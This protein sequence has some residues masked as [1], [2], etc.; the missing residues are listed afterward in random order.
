MGGIGLTLAFNWQT[1]QI[2]H[3]LLRN[4]NKT[5]FID[6]QFY[7]HILSIAPQSSIRESMVAVPYLHACSLVP[8]RP[9]S[10]HDLEKQESHGN[11]KQSIK[12]EEH[13]FKT[14]LDISGTL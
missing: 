2:K 5:D 14:Q 8:Y 10:I 12:S 6:I 3:S 9:L 7:R 13:L 1:L 4:K 11:Q